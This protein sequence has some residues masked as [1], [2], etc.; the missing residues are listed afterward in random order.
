[1]ESPSNEF[2]IVYNFFAP[3]VK[4][5]SK[6]VFLDKFQSS[7]KH[8]FHRAVESFIDNLSFSSPL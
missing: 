3:S 5:L 6:I 4:I 1:M 7:L 8:R 2:C